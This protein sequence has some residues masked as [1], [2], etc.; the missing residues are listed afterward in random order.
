V[1][2]EALLEREM[3]EVVV[4]VNGKLRDRLHVAA[5]TSEEELVALARSSE[6]VR[7]HLD[8]GEPTKTIVVPGKL[9]NFVV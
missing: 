2:D 9:V 6:R 8:G 1:A 3:L 5:S 4:Q 7:A